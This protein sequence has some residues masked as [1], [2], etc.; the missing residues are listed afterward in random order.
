MKKT[1]FVAVIAVLLAGC[2]QEVKP[3]MDYRQVP[4]YQVRQA[5]KGFGPL[6]HQGTP[7]KGDI[8]NPRSAY[9]CK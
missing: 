9:Q 4:S 3:A 7:A 6:Q 8:C 5:Y 1:I 2:A